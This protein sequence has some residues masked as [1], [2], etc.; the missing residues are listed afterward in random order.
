MILYNALY[1]GC[2]FVNYATTGSDIMSHPEKSVEEGAFVETKKRSEACSTLKL[3]DESEAEENAAEEWAGFLQERAGHRGVGKAGFGPVAGVD[4]H[5]V[6]QIRH[7]HL[8]DIAT[9]G[10]EQLVM[11]GVHW[12]RS[13][14][15]PGAFFLHS[16]T[17]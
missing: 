11:Y 17:T 6:M 5:W 13:R 10:S 16:S 3:L 8:N 7:D 1:N 9:S 12:G 4:L 14:V 15:R 2:G